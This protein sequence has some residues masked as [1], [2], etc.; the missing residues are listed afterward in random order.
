MKAQFADRMA[1]VPRSF[2]REI[3]KVA[4]QKDAISFAG[5]L[6]NADLFPIHEIELSST[7]VLREEGR[8]ALQYSDSEGFLPLR[9]YIARRYKEKQGLDIPAGQILIT[10]GSQQALDLLG[11]VFLN[12]SDEVVIEEPGY[13]GAIQ[14]F[15]VYQPKF[16]P[17]LLTHRGIDTVALKE[18]FSKHQPKLM[19]T[20][21]NFQNPSGI[22]YDLETRQQVAE[23][24]K[25]TNTFLVEDDPYGELRFEGETKPCFKT[26]LPDNTIMLGTFSKTVVPSFRIGWIVAPDEV[27]DKLIVAKQAA[28][29]HT[30]FFCQRILNQY[31]S[32]YDNNAHIRKIC[33]Q[34]GKQK[35][36]MMA[37]I[38]K[39][40]PSEVSFTHPEGGMFLWVT[41]P[42]GFTSMELLKITS[43]QKVFFVPGDQF[44]TNRSSE[45]NTLRLNFSCLNEEGIENGIK[46]LAGSIQEM[47]AKKRLSFIS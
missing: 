4:Q 42:E 6:P 5:G 45:V 10:N 47:F 22:S 23:I 36:A 11:K 27:M 3:L 41:L 8:N 40:F 15:S 34:Y 30:N 46:I 12:Q 44:Y 20:V 38:V 9:Q 29:L 35:A 24:L 7:K 18:V 43:A 28:D 14:A 17:V 39:Y 2:I 21:P 16:L 31:F 37:A 1:E 32:D 25:H 19:Y 26:F 13:L 33:T